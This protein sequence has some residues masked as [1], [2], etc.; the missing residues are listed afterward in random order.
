MPLLPQARDELCWSR[1]GDGRGARRGGSARADTRRAER[2]VRI[3]RRWGCR[4]VQGNQLSSPFGTCRQD[5]FDAQAGSIIALG[6]GSSK[7]LHQRVQDTEA[8]ATAGR[9][10]ANTSIGD[11]QPEIG[12]VF[13]QGD[14]D[15]ACRTSICI[16]VCVD[17]KLGEQKAQAY[18]AVGKATRSP[19]TSTKGVVSNPA[20]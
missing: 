12:K 15:G 9:H 18:R 4:L 6:Q 5:D 2:L 1:S 19:P 8:E 14:F 16:F 7:L 10:L 17:Q 3:L 13:D 11:D 20:P